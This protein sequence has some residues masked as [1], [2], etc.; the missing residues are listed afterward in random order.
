MEVLTP[1][2][3]LDAQ[4]VVDLDDLAKN[5]DP[6]VQIGKVER[7]SQSMYQRG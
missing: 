3:Y 6:L 7:V 1:T 2:A 5:A 4:I